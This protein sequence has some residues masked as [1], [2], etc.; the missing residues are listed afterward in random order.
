MRFHHRR[1]RP[2][3]TLIELL[4]VIA[5]IAILIGLLLPAV[6]KVREAAARLSCENNLKQIGLGVHDFHDGNGVLPGNGGFAGLNRP[7]VATIYPGGSYPNRCYLWG[8]GDPTVSAK[9]QTGGWGWAVLPYIEQENIYRNRDYGAGVKTYTCPARGRQTSQVCPDKDPVF[10]GWSIYRAGINPWGKTDYTANSEVV[11]HRGQNLSLV[12]VTDGTSNTLC[13]GEKAMDPRAYNDGGW[14]W[15]EPFATGDNGG[16][17][18]NG[19]E[20]YRDAPG[21]PYP[22]NWGS[23]H[24]AGVQFVF[25]DGSVR[26]IRFG[27]AAS[28]MKALLSPRG[29]EVLPNDF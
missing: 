7:H 10:A 29:G 25:L 4:V 23:P 12:A 26:M 24:T 28:T 1:R 21:V 15:D 18:R 6:Q 17:S 20:L 16:N 9:D 13:A 11:L 8:L 3:F 14:L 22:N 2:A 5:I 27:I 19:R